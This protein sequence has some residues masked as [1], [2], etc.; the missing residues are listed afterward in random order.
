M[1]APP[2]PEDELSRLAGWSGAPIEMRLDEQLRPYWL[3]R[4]ARHTHDSYAGVP[5]AKFPE[6][7]RVYEHLLW[8]CRPE[9]VIELGTHHGASALWFRDRLRTLCDYGLVSVPRVVTVDVE[10]DRA[11]PFLDRADPS[12]EEQITLVSGDV[13]DEAL[14]GRVARLLPSGARCLV[15]EDSAHVYDTT[16]AA[17]TGFAEFVPVG[18]FFVIEDG[19]VDVEEM[20]L[21]ETWPRGVMPAV[22]DWLAL[23]A[24]ESFRVRR[25]LELYGLTC[26]PGG[27]LQRVSPVC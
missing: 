15:V 20:R 5:M 12:W 16:M 24:G 25:D 23:S 26:H 2:R 11:R 27:I 1:T 6:D 4:A 9:A 10:A 7:L 22:A 3:E 13:C 18:G 8:T 21:E 17:L 14:P 19:C